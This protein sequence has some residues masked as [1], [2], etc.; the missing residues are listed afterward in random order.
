MCC[1]YRHKKKGR[2]KLVCEQIELICQT[3]ELAQ[4]QKKL[5]VNQVSKTRKSMSIKVQ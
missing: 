2:R 5:E 3:T 1:V 4:S